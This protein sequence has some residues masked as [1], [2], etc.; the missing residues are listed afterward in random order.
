MQPLNRILC[1]DDHADTC[2]MLAQLLKLAGYE[3]ES[4]ATAQAA[5]D[6]ARADGF[7]LYVIDH[8]LPDGDGIKLCHD[9]R[10]LHPRTPI[11]FYSADAYPAHHQEAIAAG[12]N[13]YIDKPHIEEL[14]AAVNGLLK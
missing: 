1:V 10:A 13:A 2:E 12:A 8:R 3:P 9:L 4:A 11:V 14:I 5:L 6:L 7:A